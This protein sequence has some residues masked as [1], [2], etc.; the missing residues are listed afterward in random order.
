MMVVGKP[1]GKGPLLRATYG[2]EDNMLM[3]LNPL[4]PNC[5]SP[6]TELFCGGF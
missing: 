6:L 1:K 5:K 2:W 4:N 3:Y